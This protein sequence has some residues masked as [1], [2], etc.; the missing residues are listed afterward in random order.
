[1]TRRRRTIRVLLLA[2][3]LA[4]VP[5]LAQSA[6]VA[7]PPAVQPTVPAP[8]RL[9]TSGDEAL[10][11]A[12]AAV[13]VA[14]LVEQMNTPS[15]AVAIESFD[16]VIASVRDRTVSGQ[17]RMRLG[18]DAEWI[19]FRYSTLYDT[20][21]ASAG[22]PRIMI[23]GVSAGERE[24]PNDSVLVRQLEE[25]VAVELDRQFGDTEARLQLDDI[26]TV[27]GGRRLLRINAAGIADFGRNG[28]TP[29][30]IE[31]LYDQV[32]NAWQRVNYELGV[33]TAR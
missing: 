24:V 14:A 26:T 8:Q 23:G 29:V 6:P 25:R 22:Y 20:T 10:D 11:N 15:I 31:A 3:C 21:F 18:D 19:G 32:A 7:T 27:E 2:A 4:T 5:V 1:M 12:V 9:A 17:G 33:A 16:V 28:N 30:R 13:V